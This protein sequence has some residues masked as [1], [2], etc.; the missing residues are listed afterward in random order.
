M[1]NTTKLRCLLVVVT[2]AACVTLPCTN[3]QQK[4]APSAKMR[5]LPTVRLENFSVKIGNTRLSGQVVRCDLDKV[6]IKVGIAGNEVGKTEALQSMAKRYSALA[7]INGSFFQA[8]NSGAFKPPVMT[9]ITN[10]KPVFTGNIGTTLGFIGTNEA[11]MDKA[12]RVLSA[13]NGQSGDAAG[14]AFWPRVQEAVGCGPRLVT[15]G[16]V[17]L[18]ML[19]EKFTDPKVLRLSMERSAVGLTKNRQLLLVI[20]SGTM[21]QLA[22]L[23]QKLGCAHAMNLDGG[24]SSGLYLQGR[25]LRSPGRN[26]SNALLVLPK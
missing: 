10:G 9:L 24:A 5:A 8:Y 17:S 13:L 26:L 14:D 25:Y 2:M 15:D 3:A 7:A 1:K 11:R 20:T 23:M 22:E 6:R 21:S 16:K 19:G 12:S 18:D 4:T